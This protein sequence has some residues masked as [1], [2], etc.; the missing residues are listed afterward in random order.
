MDKGED[1]GFI[2]TQIEQWVRSTV[3][4]PD[5]ELHGRCNK[6]RLAHL[7]V[8]KKPQGDVH[9][10]SVK[11][12]EGAEGEIDPLL[13]QIADAAQR[14][15]DDMQSGV[16]QYA[17]Y[18]YFPADQNYVPRKVFRVTPSDIEIER[19][20]I[21]SEPPTEKGLVAQT[22][23]HLESVMRTTTV[24]NNMIF[25]TMREEN[26]RL[27]TMVD[28][29]SQQQVDFLVLLQDLLD[30]SHSR[31]LA[32]R[33]EEANVAMKESA[34]SK[35]E[36]LLPV[37]I[38]RIAGKPVLPEESKAFMLLSGLLEGL[39]PEQQQTF[40]NMLD[41]TQLIVLAEILEDYEKKKSKVLSN[42]NALL[43]R[44][45]L[46]GAE[47]RA[48]PKV[49]DVSSTPLPSTMK[50]QERMTLI[51]GPSRDPRILKL[52]TDAQN[53]QSRFADMLRPPNPTK[54][55]GDEP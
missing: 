54:N 1:R 9:T 21:P 3:A 40:R 26:A 20:T 55:P 29:H 50:L 45:K 16:Q 53:F 34:L 38:N 48:D 49:I 6:V 52:E 46:P 42:D 14:D 31:R 30:R 51:R 8:D 39:S 19:D 15:C 33:S 18:A 35:I 5:V 13:I 25:Q 36:T 23:R 10:F 17:L 32:E 41:P 43:K 2:A 27:A 44:K 11:L 7:S 28:K 22:M 47:D 4:F 24:T 37:I 12:E